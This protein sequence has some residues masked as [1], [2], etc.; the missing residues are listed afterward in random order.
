MFEMPKKD[1]THPVD[2]GDMTAVTCADCHTGK[3]M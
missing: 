3:S 1:F 2:L